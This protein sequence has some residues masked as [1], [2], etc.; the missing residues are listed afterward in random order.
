MLTCEC[1]ELFHLIEVTYFLLAVRIEG[2]SV[3]QMFGK[4]VKIAYGI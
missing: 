4:P 2:V 3:A 1:L